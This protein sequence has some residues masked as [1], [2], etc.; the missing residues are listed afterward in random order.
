MAGFCFRCRV[1]LCLH[2]LFSRTIP[3]HSAPGGLISAEDGPFSP[4]SV[5]VLPESRI[6]RGKRSGNPAHRQKVRS[7]GDEC[8]AV[9]CMARDSHSDQEF[10]GGSTY[11]SKICRVRISHR[12]VQPLNRHDGK[13]IN[14]GGILVHYP[15]VEAI[16]C[17]SA[18]SCSSPARTSQ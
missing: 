18:G 15:L 11:N 14:P 8:I 2:G 4:V 6:H 5:S 9:P 7:R 16:T 13:D 17:R 12:A 3:V 10:G 1:V